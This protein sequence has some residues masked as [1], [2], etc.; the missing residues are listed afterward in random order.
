MSYKKPIEIFFS[1][2]TAFVIGMALVTIFR[3]TFAIGGFFDVSLQEIFALVM[4]NIMKE[5]S[6]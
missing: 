6:Q 4:N 1:L 2:F 3:N 5:L